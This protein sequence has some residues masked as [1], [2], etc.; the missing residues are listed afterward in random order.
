MT[1]DERRDDRRDLPPSA[2]IEARRDCSLGV[3][4]ALLP[5]FRAQRGQGC[6]GHI[7]RDYAACMS[8]RTSAESR[9]NPS[10]SMKGIAP[11]DAA[12]NASGSTRAIMAKVAT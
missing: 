4:R 3:A 8:R 1:N 6:P 9:K 10:P 2:R 5:G 12:M 11:N 7:A